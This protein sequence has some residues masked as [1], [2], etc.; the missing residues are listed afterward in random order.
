MYLP[1]RDY[2]HENMKRKLYSNTKCTIV[3]GVVEFG[4]Q[5]LVRFWTKDKHVQRIFL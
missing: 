4:G 1:I 3:S 2:I 5:T